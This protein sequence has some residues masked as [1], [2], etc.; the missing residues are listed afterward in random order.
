MHRGKYAARY[1][2]SPIH[3]LHVLGI[4]IV[5]KMRDLYLLLVLMVALIVSITIIKC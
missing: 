5:I 2:A 4:A 1:I 3:A